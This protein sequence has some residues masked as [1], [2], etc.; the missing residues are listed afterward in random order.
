MINF[1]LVIPSK[2][3]QFFVS[4][5]AGVVTFV[6]F[7]P[8]MKAR[9]DYGLLIFI[10]TFCLICVSGYRDDEVLDMANIRLS[11]VLIGG[12]TAVIICLC[13][14]PVWAGDD[15]HN[16]VALN[17]EKL[18]NSLQGNTFLEICLELWKEKEFG[19]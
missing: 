4:D 19:F 16:L 8:K 9:Y 10:L 18:A 6:R 14:C 3:K 17:M 13:I 5:A 2:L 7:F 12:A 11:T 15:L 1:I